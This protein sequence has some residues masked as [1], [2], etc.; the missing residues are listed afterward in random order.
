[1][2]RQPFVFLHARA[3]SRAPSEGRSVGGAHGPPRC[4][5]HLSPCIVLVGHDDD[6][7]VGDILSS[8]RHILPP[9]C[10]QF[11]LLR[12]C[13]AFVFVIF[14]SQVG[15]GTGPSTLNVSFEDVFVCVG[16]NPLHLFFYEPPTLCI[17]ARARTF[18]CP[19]RRAVCRGGAWPPT[20]SPSLV[21]VYCSCRT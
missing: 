18:P 5:L 13:L 11:S 6:D 7:V 19:L 3:P 1:M 21:P 20:L 17:F 8:L 16:G 14:P 4:P 10:A 12:L 9:N 2:N 15:I